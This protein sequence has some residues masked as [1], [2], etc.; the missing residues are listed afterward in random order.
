MTQ[1]KYAPIAL[2]D[3]VR[4]VYRLD[5]PAPW[6]ADRPGDLSPGPRSGVRGGGVPGPDQGYALKLASR[7]A[8]RIAPTVGEARGDVMA[9]AVAVGLRRAALYGRAPVAADLE[10]ALELFGYLGD[11]PEDL[12]AYRMTR[13]PGVAHDYAALRELVS[14]VPESALRLTPAVARSRRP[15]WRELLGL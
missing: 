9:A 15:Q 4:Q 12:V 3:E 2:E 13:V 5:P 8:S 1:P 11:A 7:F 6:R 10:L 14:G